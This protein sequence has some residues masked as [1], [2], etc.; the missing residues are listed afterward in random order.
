MDQLLSRATMLAVSCFLA[1]PAVA[2]TKLIECRQSSD[3]GVVQIVRATIDDTSEKAEVQVFATTA[4]CAKNDACPT[5]IYRKELLPSVLRLTTMTSTTG[6]SYEKTI[7]IDRKTLNV[8]TRSS[9]KTTAGD[10]DMTLTGTC[11]I[12]IDNSKKQL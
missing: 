1:F 7:D 10:T 8:S 3:S 4:E 5:A 12:T 9:L 11:T 6:L 2:S